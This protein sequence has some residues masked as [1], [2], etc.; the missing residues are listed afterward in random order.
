M[1]S[2]LVSFGGLALPVFENTGF[3][4]DELDAYVDNAKKLKKYCC[5][6]D[7]EIVEDTADVN[8]SKFLNQGFAFSYDSVSGN[9]RFDY[10]PDFDSSV[11]GSIPRPGFTCFVFDKDKNVVLNNNATAPLTM[12]WDDV[13]KSE[14]KAQFSS[15]FS[16]AITGYSSFTPKSISVLVEDDSSRTIRRFIFEDRKELDNGVVVEYK[17]ADKAPVYGAVFF[18]D[19]AKGIPRS[20]D[21]ILRLPDGTSRGLGKSKIDWKRIGD[22]WVPVAQTSES[23]SSRGPSTAGGYSIKCSVRYVWSL[24]MPDSIWLTG[25]EKGKKYLYPEDLRK[26]I[27]EHKLW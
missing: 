8:R 16:S 18:A 17:V 22:A 27:N 9:K 1:L 13:V 21:T 23:I 12:K 3:G 24:T 14:I 5:V 10:F 4:E 11:D 2:F 15:P 25:G 7:V 19:N 20:I 6:M 26:F